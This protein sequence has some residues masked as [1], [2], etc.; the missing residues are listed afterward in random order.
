MKTAAMAC[1]GGGHIVRTLMCHGFNLESKRELLKSLSREE[2]GQ[3][4]ILERP[5]SPPIV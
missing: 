5:T 1:A 3:I 2:H 4:Y